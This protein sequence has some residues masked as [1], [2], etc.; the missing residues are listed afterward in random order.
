[1]KKQSILLGIILFILGFIGILSILTME[2][3]IPEELMKL[4]LE[5]LTE[6]QI[7]LVTL[8]NPT[9]MLVIAIIVGVIL[10]KKVD[11]NV[12]IIEG[13]IARENNWNLKSIIK[14][15]IIGGVSSGILITLSSVIFHPFLPEEFIELG[16]NIKPSLAT[17]FLYG[18]FTE[19]ILLRFGFMTLIVWIAS[20]II[21][22][23]KN[24]IYWI[25]ILISSFIFG[26][27]HFPVA[28]QAVDNPSIGLLSYVLI[29]NTIGGLIFGWLYWKKG[30]ESAFIAHTF[31]HITMILFEPII[32]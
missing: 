23:G 31:A 15:G 24:S 30:L 10:H 7:K 20:K 5:K 29:G 32:S 18:G 19:E 13:L 26:F 9:I 22:N 17:R 4:L 3:P 21:K 6:N 2:L 16:E 14:A 25:G 8:I 27:G 1:M 12:P 11:L 28:F